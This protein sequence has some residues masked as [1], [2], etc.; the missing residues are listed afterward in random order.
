MGPKCCRTVSI[1]SFQCRNA[2]QI[3]CDKKWRMPR[4]CQ[5][6]RERRAGDRIDVDE[7]DLGALRHELFDQVCPNAC[8]APGDQDGTVD[9]A[10]IVGEG[11][12]EE[13]TFAGHVRVST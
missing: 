7:A 12:H 11:C 1:A 2:C 9:Q 6:L 8:S 13:V 10:G 5:T 4:A 3:R